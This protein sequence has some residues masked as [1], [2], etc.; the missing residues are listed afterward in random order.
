MVFKV[1]D[2]VCFKS[3]IERYGRIT[4][5]SGG[6][7]DVKVWDSDCGEYETQSVAIGKLSLD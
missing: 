7:A 3:G 1:G 2:R 4:R 6:R 5:I